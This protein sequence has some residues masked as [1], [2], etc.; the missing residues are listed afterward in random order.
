MLA[1]L[2]TK[3]GDDGSSSPASGV[4]SLSVLVWTRPLSLF[5]QWATGVQDCARTDPN[6]H[7]STHPR[8]HTLSLTHAST[9]AHSHVSHT[10]THNAQCHTAAA[11]H[12]QQLIDLLLGRLKSHPILERR[13]EEKVDVFLV[14]LLRLLCKVLRAA[15]ALKEPAGRSDAGALLEFVC[16]RFYCL[17]PVNVFWRRWTVLPMAFVSFV[18][19]SVCFCACGLLCRLHSYLPYESGRV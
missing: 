12:Y 3:T 7:P 17:E 13:Y 4:C 18:W 14:G 1:D 8:T 11:G 15:P 2:V 16:S 5:K 10:R 6:T 19:S 9:P